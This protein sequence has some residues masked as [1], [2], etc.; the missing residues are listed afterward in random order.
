MSELVREI[1][2][3]SESPRR[4]ALLRSLGLDVHVCASAYD[5]E[6][7]PRTGA[8]A[9][10]ALA[11]ARGKAGGAA[12]GGPLLVVAADTLVVV[13]GE[14][15][16]KPR[17]AREAAGMLRR[18]AGRTHVVH[19]AYAVVDRAAGRDE[20]GVSSS[21]V[22]FRALDDDAIARYVDTGEPMDKA[23]AYGIQGKGALLVE[24]IAGDFYA[25]MGLPLARLAEA[26]AR[27]GYDLL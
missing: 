6:R 11:H 20:S 25:V 5:E 18:L 13:D 21:S 3:A 4:L 14:I 23:G 2:L 19:T 8:P 17:D 9:D 16:G 10:V 24:S 27:L 15:F 1:S 7:A 22:R 12:P 26:C